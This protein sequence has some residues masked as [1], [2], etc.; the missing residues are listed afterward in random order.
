MTTSEDSRRPPRSAAQADIDLNEEMSPTGERPWAEGGANGREG[1]PAQLGKEQE[2]TEQVLGA[3]EGLSTPLSPVADGSFDGSEFLAGEVVW[4]GTSANDNHAWVS[5][6]ADPTPV[7]LAIILRG[8]HPANDN[9]TGIIDLPASAVEVLEERILPPEPKQNP[10]GTLD[11]QEIESIIHNIRYPLTAKIT[12]R[13]NNALAARAI[14][15]TAEWI[16]W[17]E[18][19]RFAF[20]SLQFVGRWFI[21]TIRNL[22]SQYWKDFGTV[23]HPAGRTAYAADGAANDSTSSVMELV[24]EDRAPGFPRAWSTP[25]ADMLLIAREDMPIIQAWRERVAVALATV[26]PVD[27]TILEVDVDP[28]LVGAVAEVSPRLGGG[29][30]GWAADLRREVTTPSGERGGFGGCRSDIS[31]SQTPTMTVGVVRLIRLTTGCHGR[32]N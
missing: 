25:P 14:V 8:Q 27:R 6:P 17:R 29:Q 13:I 32:G 26:D 7:D 2:D 30:T 20:V 19:N 11:R 23:L 22:I 31:P 24:P 15:A 3:R 1:Q 16:F 12:H 21:T 9:A 18:F 5:N 4:D 28:R 10:H